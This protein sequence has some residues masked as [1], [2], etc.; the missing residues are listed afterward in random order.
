MTCCPC[1]RKPHSL[2]LCFFW[3]MSGR[4]TLACVT[5]NSYPNL[6]TEWQDVLAWKW[7]DILACG[8]VTHYSYPNLAAEWQYVLACMEISAHSVPVCMKALCAMASV[9]S[10][11][12]ES[13]LKEGRFLCWGWLALPFPMEAIEL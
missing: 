7:Q 8:M 11:M 9:S 13:N 3:L 6:A 1:M 10:Y 4:R 2:I 12:N 5:Q